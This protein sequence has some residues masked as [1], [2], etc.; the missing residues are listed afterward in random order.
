MI[1]ASN[2]STTP[3]ANTWRR[4]HLQREKRGR[5]KSHTNKLPHH[6][7]AESHGSKHC[8][9]GFSKLP[10]LLS[11]VTVSTLKNHNRVPEQPWGWPRKHS[12]LVFLMLTLLLTFVQ[13]I[14]FLG[15]RGAKANRSPGNPA[16]KQQRPLP[17]CIISLLPLWWL[18]W[19][20]P[21]A[22]KHYKH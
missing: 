2:C 12:V 3:R 5:E 8:V 10:L 4:W 22:K 6:L 11:S 16:E 14:I 15:I 7:C 9:Q 18:R 1:A 21:F 13:G 20:T 17:W 19:D